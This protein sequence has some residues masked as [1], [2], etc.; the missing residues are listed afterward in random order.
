[1]KKLEVERLLMFLE[2][3][4][5][6]V[7]VNYLQIDDV[8][9]TTAA[10]QVMARLLRWA[11]RDGR[12]DTLYQRFKEEGGTQVL[13]ELTSNPDPKVAGLAV[14]LLVELDER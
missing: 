1:L 4:V 6:A 10:I 14:A 12:H 5:V 13:S 8:A 7:L 3:G 9:I 11:Q 2:N